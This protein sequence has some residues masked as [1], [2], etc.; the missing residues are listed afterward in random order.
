VYTEFTLLKQLYSRSFVY[1]LNIQHSPQATDVLGLLNH[2][3]FQSCGFTLL[4]H[5]FNGLISLVSDGRFEWEWVVC[6]KLL[7]SSVMRCMEHFLLKRRSVS[8]QK[9]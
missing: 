7:R 1:F 2:F 3:L 9:C 6:M 4:L 5:G 8:L